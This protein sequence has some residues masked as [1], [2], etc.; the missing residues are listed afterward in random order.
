MGCSFNREWDNSS[1]LGEYNGQVRVY[2]VNCKADT[3]I[4]DPVSQC[5]SYTWMDGI[6]YTKSNYEAT[7]T[8]LDRLGCDSIV[9]VL[10][11]T[12]NSDSVT[13]VVITC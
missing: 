5:D 9:N 11:L 7:H 13:D 4:T 10:N 6:T 12:I 1:D 3:V 2:G 8:L